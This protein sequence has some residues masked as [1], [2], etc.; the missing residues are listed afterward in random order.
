MVAG[1]GGLSKYGSKESEHGFLT[2]F[3]ASLGSICPSCLAFAPE[4]LRVGRYKPC[5]CYS[6]I[7]IGRSGELLEWGI[8]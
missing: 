2:G 1:A 5:W 4:N 3:G 8:V 7:G 6:E